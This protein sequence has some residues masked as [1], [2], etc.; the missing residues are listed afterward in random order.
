MF[1]PVTSKP[2]FV[3]QEHAL[4][5]T[6]RERRTFARLRAQN[7]GGPRWSFLDGPITA[8][9]KRAVRSFVWSTWGFGPVSLAGITRGGTVGAVEVGDHSGFGTSCVQGNGG[10][11]AAAGSV[12]SGGIIAGDTVQAPI[13]T[14]V[15]VCGNTVEAV[16]DHNTTFGGP[17]TERSASGGGRSCLG[18]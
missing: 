9:G 3:A 1:R 18:L 2:D 7:E 8:K 16:G 12:N 4:L 13:D 6:W 17:A 10:A 15:D 5:A 14:P 11:T